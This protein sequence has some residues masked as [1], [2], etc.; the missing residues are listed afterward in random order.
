MF[1]LPNYVLYNFVNNIQ[2]CL[3]QMENQAFNEIVQ[4][5]LFIAIKRIQTKY[6]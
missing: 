2:G 1:F 3:I 5:Q 4:F 6:S